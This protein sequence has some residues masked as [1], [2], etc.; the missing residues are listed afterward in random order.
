MKYLALGS[1]IQKIRE[2]KKVS[3]EA[4]SQKT[5]IEIERL[6]RI[7]AEKEQ[8]LIGTLIS[9]A[10]ALEVNV[11]DIFR[12]RISEK[13]FEIVRK[14]EREKVRP[15]MKPAKTHLFDYA[16]DLLIPPGSDKHLSAY[17]ID[18]PPHQSRRPTDDITHSGEEFMFMIEGSLEGEIGG[19]KISLSEGD[20]LYFRSTE[21]HVFYN[22]SNKHARAI[23]V[24]YPF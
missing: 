9:I 20:S 14:A 15:L 12:D 11:A 7:E 23:A 5:Q 8:P 6:K 2:K 16:Y 24:I 4:L 3:L 19:K 13:A 10:K 21:P 18:L 1:R 17:L 22:P